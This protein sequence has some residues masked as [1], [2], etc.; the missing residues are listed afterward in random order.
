MS[1]KS[2]LVV[3]SSMSLLCAASLLAAEAGNLYPLFHDKTVRVYVAEVKDTTPEHETDP[4]ILKTKIE[5]ALKRRKSIR[6]EVTQDPSAAEI[7]VETEVYEF[8]W[9]DHDPVDMLMG[10]AATAYDIATVEDYAR[11]QADMSVRDAK[12]KKELWKERVMATITKKEMPR[13]DSTPLVAEELA[14]VF[15]K[16]CFSKRRTR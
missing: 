9:T 7:A 11:L 15:I 3:F 2:S 8:M 5:E 13:K 1:A 14:K 16:D 6:F 12:T 4:K 10:A